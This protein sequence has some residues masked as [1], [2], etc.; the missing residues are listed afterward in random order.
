[1]KENLI[2]R[3]IRLALGKLDNLVLWR[4]ETGAYASGC[5]VN[6]LRTVLALLGDGKVSAAVMCLESWTRSAQWVSYGLCRGSA[7]LIGIIKPTGRFFA[8]E[9]KTKTGKA[10]EEQELFLALV[11]RLGGYA[12]LARSVDEAL[13]HVKRAAAG[14]RA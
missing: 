4:N 14:E 8:L 12:A 2:Q 1:M 5:T 7:D 13:S 9:L 10:T 6:D 11:N 3:D